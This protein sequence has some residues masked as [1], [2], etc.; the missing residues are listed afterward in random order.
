MDVDPLVQQNIISKKQYI[1]F[2]S[3][4][5][6]K[7]KVNELLDSYNSEY[8]GKEMN[9]VLFKDAIDHLLRLS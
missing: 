3:L 1:P 2:D 5:I 8:I 4:D 7:L 6:L 9:L